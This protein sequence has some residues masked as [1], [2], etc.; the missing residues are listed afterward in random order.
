LRL[1]VLVGTVYISR[2]V[3]ITRLTI[4]IFAVQYGSVCLLCLSVVKLKIIVSVSQ[5]MMPSLSTAGW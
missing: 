2:D 1:L 5:E 4:R 3:K